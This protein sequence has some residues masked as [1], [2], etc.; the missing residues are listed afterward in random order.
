MKKQVQRMV[1][2]HSRL[3]DKKVLKLDGET[4]W[5]QPDIKKRL[6]LY[7]FHMREGSFRNTVVYGY[8]IRG[9]AN[10]SGVYRKKRLG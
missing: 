1:L 10:M 8:Y 2:E 4:E 5:V 9:S 6:S 7:D 3:H